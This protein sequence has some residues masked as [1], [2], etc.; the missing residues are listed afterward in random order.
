MFIGQRI[1]KQNEKNCAIEDFNEF[2][3]NYIKEQARIT[4]KENRKTRDKI[5]SKQCVLVALKK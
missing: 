5:E 2:K 4:D 1:F 3:F